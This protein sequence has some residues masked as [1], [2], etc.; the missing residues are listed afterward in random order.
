MGDYL[1]LLK[2]LLKLEDPREVKRTGLIEAAQFGSLPVVN[3]ILDSG[4][5]EIQIGSPL[6]IAAEYGHFD[7]VKR[8][9]RLEEIASLALI[10]AVRN[11]HIQIVRFLLDSG[12]A[13]TEQA[14]FTASGNDHL[15][16][17]KLLLDRGSV[18]MRTLM[19]P[20]INGYSDMVKFLLSRGVPPE[21]LLLAVSEGHWKIVQLLLEAGADIH[22]NNN[23]ALAR[24]TKSGNVDTVKLLLDRGIGLPRR[25][26]N[27]FQ[28]A[29][30]NHLELVPLFRERGILDN[31]LFA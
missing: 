4:I 15:D 11:G 14:L 20:V 1:H 3:F 24:A 25:Y 9:F 21:Y 6:N 12:V 8:L 28:I 23:N 10:Q 26:R 16:V 18:P 5:P 27:D 19:K 2:H 13:P 31:D 22:Q 17:T 30:S 7:I 29:L